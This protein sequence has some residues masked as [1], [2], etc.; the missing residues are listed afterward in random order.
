MQLL[1][2]VHLVALYTSLV[3]KLLGDSSLTWPMLSFV[4]VGL[5]LAQCRSKSIMLQT[6]TKQTRGRRETIQYH[7]HDH[8]VLL[9]NRT[10]TVIVMVL[11]LTLTMMLI[12]A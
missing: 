9:M 6:A 7:G 3:K 1:D 2:T 12:L 8:M 5:S 10:A 11:M 4:C